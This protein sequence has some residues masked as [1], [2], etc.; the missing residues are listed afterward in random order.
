M[1]QEILLNEPE[2]TKNNENLNFYEKPFL[3]LTLN[4]RDFVL[5]LNENI[6]NEMDSNISLKEMENIMKDSP[7]NEF[8][9]DDSTDIYFT[10][11]SKY[12]PLIVLLKF[13]L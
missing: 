8:D 13:F 1:L 3:N 12:N 4:K 11:S 6:N 2:E 7:K 9:E 10:K 5:S